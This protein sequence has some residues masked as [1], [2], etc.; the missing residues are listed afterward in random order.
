M[1]I[2]DGESLKIDDVIKVARYKDR[3]ELSASSKSKIM[4]SRKHLDNILRSEKIVYGISTGFG[5]LKN[6]FISSKDRKQL[7]RNLVLSHAAG[8]GEFLSE[9]IVRA[10]ILLRI[11]SFAKGYSGVRLLLVEKLIEMLNKDVY[12]AVP[13]KGSVGA[14]GDLVP[15]SH[16]ALV[17]IGEGKVFQNNKIID[18]MVYFKQNNI[19]TITLMEKEGLSLINGTQIMSAIASLVCYD[20]TRLF[21]IADIACSLTIEALKCSLEPFDLRYLNLR[22][23]NGQNEVAQNVLMLTEKSCYNKTMSND[24]QDAYSIRCIPQVHGASR[25]MLKQIKAMLQVEINSVTDNPIILPDNGEVLC[26]GNFHGQPIALSMDTLKIAIAEIGSISECRLSRMLDKNCSKLPGFLT[27]NP[28]LNSGLMITQYTAASLVSENKVLAHPASVD[29]IPTSANQEDHVSM[30]TIAA[31]QAQD[32][33]SNVQYII[34]IEIL[35]AVQ[36]IDLMS[37]N[38]LGKGSQVSYDYIRKYVRYVNEDRILSIDIETIINMIRT[39]SL[40]NTVE[41]SIGILK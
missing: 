18:S 40:L 19:K 35:A 39:D 27:R 1:I 17:L 38:E 24:I 37:S 2:I 31:R 15:L 7:Q 10:A 16:I 36:G 14:S 33:L 8:V 20:A 6:V 23:Y 22:P 11:N 30:G 26:G 9:E 41:N 3:I 21:K 28:G 25:D 32:I 34:A 5:A 4:T 13:S 29:S 12:P